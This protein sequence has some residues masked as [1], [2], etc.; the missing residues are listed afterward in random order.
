MSNDEPHP[1]DAWLYEKGYSIFAWAAEHGLSKTTLYHVIGGREPAV[2]TLIAIE[3]ATGGAVTV[4]DC[5][6][7][8]DRQQDQ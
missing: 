7:W 1:L 8:F 6:N 2:K 5:V 4:S 3:V